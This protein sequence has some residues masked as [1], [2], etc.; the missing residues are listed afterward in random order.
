MIT[1]SFKICKTQM[2]NYHFITK[3][4]H[5]NITY[6]TQQMYSWKNVDAYHGHMQSS[7]YIKSFFSTSF[8]LYHLQKVDAT[9]YNCP[10]RCGW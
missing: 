2:R 8:E 3:G 1:Y 4:T 6:I 9:H 7:L 5:L 10:S